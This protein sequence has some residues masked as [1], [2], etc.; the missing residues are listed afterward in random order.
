MAAAVFYLA[1]AGYVHSILDH[2]MNAA[3]RNPKDLYMNVVQK[4][5]N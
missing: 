1:E 2:K 5:V 3:L 4:Y